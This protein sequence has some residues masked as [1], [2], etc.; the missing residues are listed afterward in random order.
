MKEANRKKIPY[1]IVVGENEVKSKIY[2]L[3]NMNTGEQWNLSKE[4]CI[5]KIYE[6]K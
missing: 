2:A 1:I 3:K 4:E 5:K 6:E